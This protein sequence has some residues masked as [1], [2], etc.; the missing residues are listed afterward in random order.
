MLIFIMRL[1][2][3]GGTVFCAINSAYGLG[4]LLPAVKYLMW[5]IGGMMELC[6]VLGILWITS[7]EAKDR[8]GV[9]AGM[10]A[11][12]CI[13]VLFDITGLVAMASSGYQTR[14]NAV[15][16][17]NESAMAQV[18]ADLGAAQSKVASLNEEIHFQEAAIVKADDARVKARDD[19]DRIKAAIAMKNDAEKSKATLVA[20]RDTAMRNVATL[21]AQVGKVKG[22]ATNAGSEFAAVQ[23]ISERFDVP[24]KTINTVAIA[25]V[26]TISV[27]LFLFMLIAAGHSDTKKPGKRK[28]A[29][30]VKAGR[31]GGQATKTNRRNATIATSSNVQTLKAAAGKS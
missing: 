2:G 3:F 30:H 24:A 15:V 29:K 11:L 23:W 6:N 8:H 9:R 10:M 28:S 5:A 26:S 13:V 1:V 17:A 27:L 19:K 12:C 16:A 21:T 4:E 20:E 25:T 18:E 22:D 7:P 31:L 14:V